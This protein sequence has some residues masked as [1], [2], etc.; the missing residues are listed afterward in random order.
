MS[1]IA[2]LHNFEPLFHK[3]NT[4]SKIVSSLT[5]AA[6]GERVGN[7]VPMSAAGGHEAQQPRADPGPFLAV[8]LHMGAEHALG[9]SAPGSGDVGGSGTSHP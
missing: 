6:E 5:F 7:P 3:N 8:V 2:T 4:I 9:K 1:K